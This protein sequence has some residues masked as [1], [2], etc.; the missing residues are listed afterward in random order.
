MHKSSFVTARLVVLV[1]AVGTAC[2]E[3]HPIENE[4]HEGHEQELTIVDNLP[5]QVRAMLE[6]QDE[7]RKLWEDHI[8]WT[9]QFIVSVAHDLPDADPTAQRLLANQVDIGDVF[10]RFYG[11]AV[12]N[13][14]T[15]LLTDHILIAAQILAAAKAGD[16]EGVEEANQ[17][18]IANADEIAGLWARINRRS[19]PLA[20]MKAHMREHLTLTLDEAVLRLTG[21]FAG[22]I[23]KYEEV[24]E[25]I[26]E[27]ADMLSAG[28]IRQFPHR[29]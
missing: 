7:M 24:H 13:E 28:I 16:A 20:E 3:E 23:A 5:R 1:L 6:F 4:S 29:F 10:R 27:M 18:W 9:R 17:A 11:N 21:D 8:V 19:W 2:A 15:D 12:G 25:S 22:D 14:L 26:L